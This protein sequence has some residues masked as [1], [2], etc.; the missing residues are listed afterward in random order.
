MKGAQIVSGSLQN[1]LMS[2]VTN[3]GLNCYRCASAF[4]YVQRNVC[5]VTHLYDISTTRPT[6]TGHEPLIERLLLDCGLKLE[7]QIRK[8][9]H[10]LF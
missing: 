4:V 9:A 8:N 7:L 6:N 1:D 10:K 3:I 5:S 2:A